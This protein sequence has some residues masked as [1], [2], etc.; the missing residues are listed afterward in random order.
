MPL[1]NGDP[2]RYTS[3]IGLQYNPAPSPDSR[4]LL[5]VSGAGESTH[6]IWR[7]DLESL[8]LQQLTAND[9][10]DITPAWSPDGTSIVFAS[11]R[12]GDYEIWHMDADGDPVHRVTQHNGLDTGPVWS[13]DGHWLA[14]ESNRAGDVQ[15]WIMPTAGGEAQRVSPAT[16]PCRNV[17]WKP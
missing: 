9:A 1:D 2:V 4:W 11:N 6:E 14:F 5:Y 17:D 10:F 7:L 16:R 13:P 15:I 12:T 3:Q 8:A